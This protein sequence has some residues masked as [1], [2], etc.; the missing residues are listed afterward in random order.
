MAA[1]CEFGDFLE[2]ALRDRLVCGIRD[3]NVQRKLLSVSGLTLKK[4]VETAVAMELATKQSQEFQEKPNLGTQGQSQ[5]VNKVK[6][7]RPDVNN[8]NKRFHKGS[9]MCYRCLDSSHK[10]DQCPFRK[11]SCFHCKKVGHIAKA[12]R[13]KAK[14]RDKQRSTGQSCRQ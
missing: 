2:Q 4:A 9:E 14:Q 6:V 1:I 10:P 13:K 12:C 5:Q 8:Q 11:Q 3:Q 7:R